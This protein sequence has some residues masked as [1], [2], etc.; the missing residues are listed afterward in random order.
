M[1]KLVF[2][3]LPSSRS[4]PDVWDA[5]VTTTTLGASLGEVLF[6]G[7]ELEGGKQGWNFFWN[8]KTKIL[9]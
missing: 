7:G 4:S 2:K 8:M 9:S 5:P 1:G 3:P 6:T